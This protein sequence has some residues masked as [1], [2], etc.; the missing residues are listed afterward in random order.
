V[1]HSLFGYGI[2]EEKAPRL[3]PGQSIDLTTFGGGN[4][5]TDGHWGAAEARGTWTDGRRAELVVSFDPAHTTDLIAEVLITHVA[6]RPGKAPVRVDVLFERERLAHWVVDAHG[7][8]HT[9]RVPLPSRLVVGRGECVLAFEIAHE[10]RS[11]PAED[12]EKGDE[13]SGDSQEL[14]VMIHSVAFHDTQRAGYRIDTAADVTSSGQGAFYMNSGWTVPDKYGAW[15]LGPRAEL[16]MY[17][18]TVPTDPLVATVTI[19]DAAVGDGFPHLDVDVLFNGQPVDRWRLGPSRTTDERRVVVTA[20]SLIRQRPLHISFV[21]QRPRS[22]EELGWS[23]DQ[24]PL[25]FRLTQLRMTPLPKYH[26]GEVIDFTEGGNAGQFLGSG[27]A[28]PDDSGRWTEGE[29]ATLRLR[30]PRLSPTL[31]VHVHVNGALAEEW[32]FGPDRSP[33]VRTIALEPERVGEAEELVITFRV[34]E[35]RSPA[36]LGWSADPRP[37]GIRI[38]RARLGGDPAHSMVWAIPRQAARSYSRSIAMRARRL[39][40]GRLRPLRDAMRSGFAGRWSKRRS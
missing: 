14:G 38:A 6:K 31:P 15:T 29:E 21:V 35:P 39:A 27:W 30:V 40:S 32:V 25:G 5:Y 16:T 9:F 22:P 36:S 18:E 20:E 10:P 12:A 19:S 26:W 8:V 37:L 33:H 3:G 13:P 17:L 28:T 1:L 34:R 23:E 11:A 4:R 2:R 7:G 24:R